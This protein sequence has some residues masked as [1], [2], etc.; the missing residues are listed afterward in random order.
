MTTPIPQPSNG[1]KQTSS[2]LQAENRYRNLQ[3][4]AILKLFKQ[5]R[6]R[7]AA[8]ETEALEWFEATNMTDPN[9]YDVLTPD[10]IAECDS[11][12]K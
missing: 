10:E 11:L 8:N 7:V 12:L 3:C 1:H 9:P 2:V 4:F 5:A 6:G